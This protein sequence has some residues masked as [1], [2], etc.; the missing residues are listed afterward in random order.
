MDKYIKIK[1]LEEVSGCKIEDIKELTSGKVY[2]IGVEVEGI[3]K[4]NIPVMLS[5]IRDALNS[6][7]ID[8][9]VYPIY[10]N[11]PTLRI[12]EIEP[13]VKDISYMYQSND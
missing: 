12:Y 9:I 7:N 3:P 13:K 6:R 11:K 5:H 4:D 10:Q 1:E 2:V 8:A